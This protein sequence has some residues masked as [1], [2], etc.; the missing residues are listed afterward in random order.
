MLAPKHGPFIEPNALLNT[1]GEESV[2]VGG[3][4]VVTGRLAERLAGTVVGLYKASAFNLR[5]WVRD[6]LGNRH[7]RSR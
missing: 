4:H 5:L 3:I 1:G 2:V 7:R 6:Q